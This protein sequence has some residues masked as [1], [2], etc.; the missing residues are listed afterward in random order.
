MALLSRIKHKLQIPS[1]L[2]HLTYKG[3]NSAN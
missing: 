1:V 3:D 2:T